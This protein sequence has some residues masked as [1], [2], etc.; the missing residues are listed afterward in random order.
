MR[1]LVVEDHAETRQLLARV[2][3]EAGHTVETGS[4]LAA[5]RRLLAGEPHEALVLDWMLPDGSGVDFCRELRAARET[6]PILVLTARGEVEDRVAGLNA[7]ADDYLR[8]P[9]AVAELLAR[10]RALTRRG[11]RFLEPVVCLGDAEVR[12]AERCVRAAGR[13][14]PLTAREFSILEVLLRNRGRPV[15][16]STIL[17]SVWGEE[18]ENAGASLEVLIARLRRKLAP[19]GGEGPIHTHRGFGYAIG[20]DT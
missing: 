5:A 19:Q 4:D 15:S 12:L 16:R 10:V 14:V 9:F 1:I 7:G 18:D 11:P 6:I 17:L 2:L 3:R 8:K 13:N 20:E